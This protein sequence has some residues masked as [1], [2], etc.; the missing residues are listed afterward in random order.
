MCTLVEV[1]VTS[2]L[3]VLLQLQSGTITITVSSQATP[4]YMYSLICC[5]HCYQH[6]LSK[7]QTNQD[8]PMLKPSWDATAFTIKPKLLSGLATVSQTFFWLWPPA[9][10]VLTL[11]AHIHVQTCTHTYRHTRTHIY[12]L[13]N[14]CPYC[15]T[16]I[17]IFSISLFWY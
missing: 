7:W 3:W 9:R 11:H 6:N 2:L 10:Q 1:F 5:A 8:T 15:M 16:Y 17:L 4:S 12:I 13:Q 14:I